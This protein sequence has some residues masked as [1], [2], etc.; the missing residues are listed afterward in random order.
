MRYAS[1]PMPAISSEAKAFVAGATGYVGRQVVRRL[2][3]EGIATL[4]HVRPGSPRLQEWQQRFADCGASTIT[5]PWNS[6]A[7]TGALAEH[8]PTL[9]FALIGTTK[10]RAKDEGIPGDIFQ[11]IDYGLT[12]ML[13]NGC[14][15]QDSPPRFVYLS[16]IGSSS[17]SRSAYLRARGKIEDELRASQLSWISAQPAMITGHDRDVDRPA[18]RWGAAIGDGVLGAASRLGASGWRE[19]YQSTSATRLAEALVGLALS[20][21]SGLKSGAALRPSVR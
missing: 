18:E 9:V 7:L 21:E 20:E 1:F 12:R 13:L 6:E 10:A 5:T 17:T 16:S 8:S 4:A 15:A 19:R 3:E 2:C 11:A 14:L